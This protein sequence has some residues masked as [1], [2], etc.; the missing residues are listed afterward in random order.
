M[1]PKG[2]YSEEKT[3]AIIWNC[4]VNATALR[5]HVSFS[6]PSDEIRFECSNAN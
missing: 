2:K 4:G 3:H 6:F 5:M 1:Q